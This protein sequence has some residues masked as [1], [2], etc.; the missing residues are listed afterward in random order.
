MWS[1]V[2]ELRFAADLPVLPLEE[3]P[4][5]G[6]HQN[7][8]LSHLPLTGWISGCVLLQTPLPA[9]PGLL[10]RPAV[11][12]ILPDGKCPSLDTG[13]SLQLRPCCFLIVFL[14]L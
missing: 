3:G 8:R 1:V 2:S 13:E 9:S 4:I 12:L 11:N 7:A 5:A 10:L 14:C 6:H